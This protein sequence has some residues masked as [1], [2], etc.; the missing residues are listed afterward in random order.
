MGD[1][2]AGYL[3]CLR[4][5]TV[6]DWTAIG[7][8]ISCAVVVDYRPTNPHYTSR[9]PNKP[10]FGRGCGTRWL[11]SHSQLYGPNSLVYYYS[12]RY[13]SDMQCDRLGHAA[14]KSLFLF[15]FV[16]FGLFEP[17]AVVNTIGNKYMH[18]RRNVTLVVYYYKRNGKQKRKYS[19]W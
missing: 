2:L 13:I 6:V 14:A 18:S 10:Y 5:T 16:L 17:M 4:W 1:L 12:Y 11:R 8:R 7:R 9:Q 15:D 19:W 3:V